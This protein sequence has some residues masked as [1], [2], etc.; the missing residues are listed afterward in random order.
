[1]GEQEGNTDKYSGTLISYLTLIARLERTQRNL[2]LLPRLRGRRPRPPPG[3]PC[4][5]HPRETSPPLHRDLHQ[6]SIFHHLHARHCRRSGRTWHLMTPIPH[7][8]H[9]R[10]RAVT[11]GTFS[12]RFLRADL[13][14]KH[15]RKTFA[16]DTLTSFSNQPQ[17]HLHHH[18]RLPNFQSYPLLTGRP[19][20]LPYQPSGF[21][22]CLCLY[23]PQ[24]SPLVQVRLEFSASFN[25][26]NI[27]AF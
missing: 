18:R 11:S 5:R 27:V 4:L 1:M 2:H 26:Y 19:H 17:Q 24:F 21:C 8:Q 3:W 22:W 16:A 10:A 20:L 9:P 7:H 15:Q 12:R 14:L 25:A 6:L 23:L 13:V